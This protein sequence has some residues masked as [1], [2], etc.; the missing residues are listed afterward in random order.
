L[1]GLAE[2]ARYALLL[3]LVVAPA[4]AQP[5]A[6]GPGETLTAPAPD[7][8]G[9]LLQITIRRP[10]GQGPFPLAIINHGSSPSAED[11]LRMNAPK[12]SV[13]TDWFLRRG[14]A[15]ALPL[16]R[17]YGAVGGNWDEGFGDCAR[18]DYTKAGIETAR[19]IEAALTMLLEL[20]TIQKRGAIIVGQSAGGWG[21][22]AL[23][24]RPRPAVAGLVNFAG[25]RGGHKNLQPNSNCGPDDLIFAAG[26]FGRG[27]KTPMVWIYTE[28]DSFFAPSIARA[29]HQSFVASGGVAAFHMLP[30]FAD[31]GHTLMARREGQV[32]WEPIVEGFLRTLPNSRE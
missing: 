30:A 3:A 29:M 2:C 22:V 21:T 11:R 27:A 32:L 16:R 8:S 5:V 24:A 28:N 26:R 7:T 4:A 17:G 13:I 9:R 19:D 10:Q 18:P 12:F 6:S 31:D 15:V 25:G 1:R 20:P 14:H 23:A